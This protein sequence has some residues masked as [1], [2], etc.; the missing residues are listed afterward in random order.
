MLENLPLFPLNTVLFPGMPLNLHIFEE[1]YK[2]MINRCIEAQQPFGVVLIQEGREALGP[3]AE[4]HP[5]GCIA[6]IT[7]VQRLDDGR[8]NIGAVGQERFQIIS[9]DRSLPYLVGQVEVFPLDEPDASGVANAA[10]RLRPWVERYM[11]ALS[12]IEGV[13][14]SQV[15]LPQDPRALAYLAAALLQ[16]PSGQKQELLAVSQAVNLIDHVRDLYRMEVALAKTL[17]QEPREDQ[18]LFSLN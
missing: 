13:E 11:E 12:Q 14:L 10:T 8:L 4:P 18:G 1:R 7:Q 2:L 15:E 6:R 16:I 17:V 5:V 3:L 9:L